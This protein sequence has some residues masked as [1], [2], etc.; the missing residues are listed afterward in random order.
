MQPTH[1]TL[2]GSLTCDRATIFGASWCAPCHYAA[3]HLR[4]R[5]VQ[6]EERDIEGDAE[7]KLFVRSR[8]GRSLTLPVIDICGDV[9]DGYNPDRLDKAITRAR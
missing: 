5:G 9:L 2:Q 6:V 8:S 3:R 1:A 7:A 4:R